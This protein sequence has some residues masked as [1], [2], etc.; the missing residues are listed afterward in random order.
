M[1][2][3]LRLR[4]H[5]LD[6]QRQQITVRNGKGGKDRRTMLP[7]RVGEK[8]RPHLEEVRRLH[9]EDLAEGYGRVRL[10]H[11]LGRQYPHAPVEWGWPWVFPQQ[12]RWH[13]AVT[14]EQGRHHLDPTLVQKSSAAGCSDLR[15]HHASHGPQLSPFIRHPPVGKRPGHRH[16]PGADGPSRHQNNNDRHPYFQ[17]WPS[18][19]PEPRRP[20]AKS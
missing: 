18:G 17:P 3:A 6:F 20:F 16:H 9:R 13:N 7:A 5:D 1:M 12:R 19:H 15:N 2:E 11:A 14:G 8:L 10:P 4:V